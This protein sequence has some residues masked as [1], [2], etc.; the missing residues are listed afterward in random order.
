MKV[1]IASIFPPSESPRYVF[2][3]TA[4]NEY[5]VFSLVDAEQDFHFELNDLIK[6]EKVSLGPVTALNMTKNKIT[7][8]YLHDFAI[9]KDVIRVRYDP[10]F[11]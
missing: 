11:P 6:F 2:G 1:E 9:N 5:V 3:K 4:T 8:V 7:E 10:A